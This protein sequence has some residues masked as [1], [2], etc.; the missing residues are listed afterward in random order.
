MATASVA[1]GS[2]YSTDLTADQ[3]SLIA[4]ILPV[5]NL[6]GRHEK[7]PRIE[8]VNAGFY[9][10]RTGC[11]WRHPPHAFPPWQTVYRYFRRWRDDGT[12]DRGHALLR[13][14]DGRDTMASAG[15]I[16]A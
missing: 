4:S 12:L 7:H 14:S 2:S 10:L 1:S 5:P 11:A 15:R 13:D 6:T 16:D 8:I 3:G 9:V